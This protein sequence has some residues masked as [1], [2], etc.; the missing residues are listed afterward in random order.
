MTQTKLR[1]SALAALLCTALIHPGAAASDN[2]S[3]TRYY[4][5]AMKRYQQH[6]YDGATIQLRNALK[7]DKNQLAVHLL[8]GKT[9]LANGDVANAEFEFKESLRLGVNRIEVAV[10]L[11]QTFVAQGRQDQVF[12]DQRTALDGLPART[13]Y[14][15]LLLR[16]AAQLDLGHPDAALTELQAAR[17]LNPTDPAAWLAEVPVRVRAGQFREAQDAVDQALRLAPGS[18]DALYQQATISHVRGQLNAA[19]A[20]YDAALK[21]APGHLEARIARA[22]LLVD[23][24]RDQ[25]ASRDLDELNHLDPLDPRANYLRGL[26]AQRQGDVNGAKDYFKAVTEFLDPAPI[27][28]LRYRMQLLIVEGLSHFALGELEKAKPY[29]DM[30]WRQQQNGPLAKLLAQIAIENKDGG[31]AIDLLDPY[32]KTHPGDAQALLMLASVHLQDGRYSKATALMQQALQAKDSP[33]YHAVLGLSLVR[34]GRGDQGVAQLEQAFKTDPHQIYAGLALVTQY[35]KTGQPA[36]ALGIANGMAKASPDNAGVFV[37]L[38][39][40]RAAN[41][42]AAGARTA[43]EKAA[44]L[45]PTLAEAQYGLADLEMRAG[46]FE[47]AD[48]RLRALLKNDDR[49]PDL[50]IQL[51]AL[52]ELWGKNAQAQQYVESA[53]DASDA[54][55]TRANFAL[56]A[57]YMHRGLASKALDA[58]KVLLAKTPEDADALQAYAGAQVGTGDTNGARNTLA[59]AA[60]RAGFDAGSLVDIASAQL[61]I[62]DVAGAAYSLGKA[63]Q[64]QPNFVPAMALMSTVDLLQNNAASAEQRAKEIIQLHPKAAI[65]YGLLADVAASRGQSAAQIDALRRAYELE[66]RPGNL[67]RLFRALTATPDGSKAA[68]D[69]AQNWIKTHPKDVTM[70]KALGDAYARAG[71]Y[72]NARR[73]YE[74]ALAQQPTDAEALNNLANVLIHQNDPGATAIAEKALAQ[75]GRNAL[76]IDTA[77]WAYYKAGNKDRALQLLRDARLRDPTSPDIHFHLGT[78]LAQAGRKDEARDEIKAALEAG[79]PF[80]GLQDARALAATL[81]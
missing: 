77:G 15:M 61:R 73:S 45:A 33:S 39:Q 65:G 42:D 47:P 8:L 7:I 21:A 55:Q 26:L 63:L 51:G 62:N 41:G 43:Y 56:V 3:A 50:L 34:D 14:E 57:W 60:R 72:P 68:T 31:T 80:E 28:Y 17:S 76:V 78:V 19:L 6:D 23:M 67:V 52:Y 16:A 27:E 44:K 37:V 20:G 36:K 79:R 48:K 71:N 38:G 70:H 54:K 69:L 46:N 24:N 22:G 75:D 32:V 53:A 49:N 5:D 81:K 59:Q 11:A 10:P 1:L 4:D 29:L 66:P 64:G 25:D 30:A 13:R 2:A 9:L 35:L 40:S 18:G 12:T 58:A 74:A